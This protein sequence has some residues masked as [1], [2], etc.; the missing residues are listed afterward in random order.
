MADTVLMDA[1]GVATETRPAKKAAQHGFWWG[2][3][4]RKSAVARVRGANGDGKFFI[5]GREVD[6]YFLVQ[7]DR[8]MAKAPLTAT[9]QLGKVDV[10]ANVNGGGFAGQ[11]GAVVLGLA[12]ALK[13]MNTAFE[14]A[15]RD[16]G[17][18]TR[19]SRMVERKK[20]G[21]SGARRRFQFSKR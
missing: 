17:Y 4:R 13:G 1:V 6:T 19:D 15:L 21:R 2:T 3:G 7:R 11:A 8:D 12:R 20:Y 9:E 5:N 16:N 14:G 10:Y 18:L